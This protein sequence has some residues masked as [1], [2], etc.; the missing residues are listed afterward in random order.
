MILNNRRD[1]GY[2]IISRFEE[3]FRVFLL[4]SLSNDSTDIFS[5]IPEGVILKAN[6]RGNCSTNE[7]EDYSEFFLNIDFPDLSEICLFKNNYNLLI[8]HSLK[9]E[10]FKDQMSELYS[11]RCKIAHI[12]G[13]FTSIDLDKL[14][15]FTRNISIIFHDNSFQD[16]IKIILKEP[17]KVLIK[18]PTGFIED[19]LESNGI[20]NNLPIPDY[21]YE[22]GFVGRLEDKKKI[23]KFLQSE[24]FP[25]ITITGAGG[26]GKTSLALKIIQELT[27]SNEKLFECIIWLSAK[28]NRLSSLGIEDIEPTLKSYEE[29]LDTF[30]EI[31]NFKEELMNDS[32]ESKEELTNTI[33]DLNHKI[34]V[35][36]DNLE[37]I[38][39]ERI[40]NFILDA[41]IKVKFLI[42]S[43][44][45]I[46]QVER[47][48][49]LKELKAKEAIYLFRQLAKDK[50]MEHLTSL[51]DDVILKY[52]QKVSFYPLAIKWVLGQVARGKDIN[53]IITSIHNEESDIS[54]FCFEQIFL[55]LSDNCKKILFTITCMET[56]PTR[57]ILQH[58]TELDENTFEDTIE[59]LILASLII[60][61]QYQDDSEEIATKYTLLPL[62]RG[63]VRLQLNK[64][65]TLKAQLN[66]R[67]IDVEST[68]SESQRA[69]K[70]YKH[71]LHNFGAKTDE[72]KIATIISQ[73][74]FQKYQ[75]GNYELAVE[76]YKRAL[77]IAPNFSP[78]YRNWGVM[79]SYE[80]HLEEAI[81][82]MQKAAKIE[83]KDAQIYLL[84][85]NIYRK[86]GKFSDAHA[87]Y[88]IAYNLTPDDPIV[89]NAFGQ[90]NGRLGMYQEANDLL[91][92]SKESDSNFNSIKHK[93]ITT[94]SLSE[95]YINWGDYLL[96]DKDPK[97][98]K[99]KYELAIS[100]CL[101]AIKSNAKDSKIFTSLTKAQL[102]KAHLYLKTNR[103]RAAVTSLKQIIDSRDDSFKHSLYK[104]T[105]MIDLAEYYFRKGNM[106]SSNYYLN[107]IQKEI[108]FKPILRNPK[109]Q[110]LND[111]LR[112]IQSSADSD[113]RNQG[114]IK[115]ANS[116]YGY[117]IIEDDFK[118]TYIAGATDFMPSI[119]I[120]DSSLEGLNV[121]F[122]KKEFEKKGK[123][124]KE[125]KFVKIGVANYADQ[126]RF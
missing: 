31:F 35:V 103:E 121:T 85:G 68:I 91:T 41:P 95:N 87:K 81:E 66:T 61:E 55:T 23:K 17:E 106:K 14:I 20:I 32:I 89:L 124:K 82:L 109:F 21:D 80:N 94:T 111:R 74:A 25:V 108:K 38:T 99:E 28:E 16:F 70:E 123:I 114:T 58:I 118:N 83:P 98:A 59:E 88:Q 84:W 47:R 69:K 120:I 112:F 33:I 22:G 126:N 4:D 90:A 75:N 1:A 122:K 29:L 27:Q 34:L 7:W 102:K 2:T 6:E 67:I 18:I 48:H 115:I 5:N 36:V 101:G 62:T 15:E 9:K 63:F 113:N 60:P 72:E 11:L 125:A 71:S 76:E 79:E 42:T 44:K 64:N 12:K 56:P 78:V 73:N 37:T 10:D 65:S 97:G 50:Q 110:K 53:R 26:V 117:V 13:F 86:N 93:I 52:V 92:K 8:K 24:K 119:S 40:I 107:T 19:Y 39:D 77:K 30:I 49:E 45:G 100:E 96:R 116:N 46:G 54:K 105:A 104:L 51:N 3:Q 57:T 43:R